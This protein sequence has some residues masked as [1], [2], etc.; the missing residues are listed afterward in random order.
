M[1]RCSRVETDDALAFCGVEG[2]RM[3][4]DSSDTDV[5]THLLC[6][7]AQAVALQSNI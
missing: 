5:A 4:S 7:S 3:S 2:A 6:E 1:S